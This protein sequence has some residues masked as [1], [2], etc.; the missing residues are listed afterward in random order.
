MKTLALKIDDTIVELID[1]AQAGHGQIKIF[2]QNAVYSHYWG[3]MGTGIV[4][5]V[6]RIN[7]DYFL[8][9]LNPHDR[10]VFCSKKTLQNLRKFIKKE[11][12]SHRCMEEQKK[13]RAEL[14]TIKGKSERVAASILAELSE[15][16]AEEL[17]EVVATIKSDPWF[18]LE[19][20]DS[21]KDIWLGKLFGQL[22]KR[23]RKMING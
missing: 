16:Q 17:Q 2:A 21:E 8:R 23:L 14:N 22:Q 3:A 11:L 15:G 10:G 7:Q 1:F 5:F 4:D 13:L 20:I 12:P 18:F 6:A 19:R 9:K